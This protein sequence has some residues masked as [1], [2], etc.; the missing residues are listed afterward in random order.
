M[1]NRGAKYLL[2]FVVLLCVPLLSMYPQTYVE[3]AFGVDLVSPS[4]L[5]GELK[6]GFSAESSAE[7]ETYGRIFGTYDLSGP[8]VTALR[9]LKADVGAETSFFFG[10]WVPL[11]GLYGGLSS[12]DGSTGTAYSRVSISLTGNGEDSS[13]LMATDGTLW[14]GVDAGA[15][16][17]G[18][19]GF[20]YLAGPLVIK[21]LLGASAFYVSG[22]LRSWTLRPTLSLSWYPTFPL[23]ADVGG[24]W[25]HSLDTPG[26][27]VDS[28]PWSLRISAQSADRWGFMV[29]AEGESS[30]DRFFGTVEGELTFDLV[31]RASYSSWIFLRSIGGFDTSVSSS[32][33]G[34]YLCS[35]V[36]FSF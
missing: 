10:T 17:A 11:V 24:G 12:P 34:W 4:A 16:L 31:R 23:Q 7:S 15:E 28:F 25:K 13:I 22:L 19:L 2:A 32:P 8:S 27:P 26:T 29:S 6:G 35:G 18:R 36:A 9:P 3:P 20:S 21:P 33:T 30:V 5:F 1:N 14:Y